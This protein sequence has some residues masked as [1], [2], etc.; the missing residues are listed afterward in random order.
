MITWIKR[1]F[2]HHEYEP[3]P[4]LDGCGRAVYSK[5]TKMCKHCY[6]LIDV[7]VESPCTC[8]WEFGKTTTHV[9]TDPGCPEHGN[10]F[11]VPK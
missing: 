6:K 7:A 3:L 9:T 1:L 11:A 5:D 2:C 8:K 10:L 4:L